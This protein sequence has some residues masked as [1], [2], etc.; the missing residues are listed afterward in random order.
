MTLEILMGS[1][2][3]RIHRGELVMLKFS[4]NYFC[5][6]LAPLQCMVA[7]LHRPKAAGGK[8]CCLDQSGLCSGVRI[9]PL[10]RHALSQRTR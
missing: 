4:E 10:G 9:L 1:L 5:D 3:E 6:H 8:R 2:S 7:R